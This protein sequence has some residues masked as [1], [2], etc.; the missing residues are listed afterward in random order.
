[1]LLDHV[2]VVEE[3][4]AGGTD[5]DAAVGGDGQALVG[6]FQDIPGVLQADQERGAPALPPSRRDPLSGGDG[7]GPF[8]QV[9]DAEQ[10]TT[11]RASEQVL[12]GVGSQER[13]EDG[14]RAARVQAG[15]DGVSLWAMGYG[16][17]LWAQI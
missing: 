7:L 16:L 3:P 4:L 13:G 5:A 11:D 14:E 12:A 6:V 1:V 10:L 2:V 15:D 9:F 17:W 8:G